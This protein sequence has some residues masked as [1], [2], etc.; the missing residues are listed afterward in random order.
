MR[1]PVVETVDLVHFVCVCVGWYSWTRYTTHTNGSRG[2]L[3]HCFHARTALTH[4]PRIHK[5]L[6][7]LGQALV[8]L[9]DRVV[10]LVQQL[11][12]RELGNHCDIVHH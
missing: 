10:T 11:E 3:T 9:V 8:S 6:C 12:D 4:L 7:E 2:A 1:D 5:F